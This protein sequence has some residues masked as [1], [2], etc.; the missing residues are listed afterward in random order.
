M[1][2]TYA[3]V[4][5]AGKSTRMGG[6][7]KQLL[8]LSGVP[9][10]ARTL[11]ALNSAELDGIVLAVP[12][13]SVAE[14]GKLVTDWG[15]KKI[16]AVVPGGFNR[17]QSVLAG[18]LAVP[19]E[20]RLVLVHDGARP[21]VSGKQIEVVI[22]AAAENGAAT[23]AVP[24]KDTVKEADANCF[25]KRTPDRSKLW[26]TQTPQGFIFEILMEAH[27]K[28]RDGGTVYTDD[29]SMVEAMGRKVKLVQGSYSNIKITTPEDIAVAEALLK[30]RNWESGIGN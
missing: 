6:A 27:L 13:D 24:V 11:S 16:T 9:V 18:L 17:Q 23:L 30:I 1:D 28:A 22:S 5:A 26:L 12:G 25:V 29:A 19:S 2:K 10:L 20:C 3:V 14:Y 4:V 21:L 8:L 7:N 15:L